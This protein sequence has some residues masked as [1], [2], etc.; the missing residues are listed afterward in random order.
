MNPEQGKDFLRFS[1]G[2]SRAPVGGLDNLKLI[3]QKKDIDK[4]SV[5]HACF[6][7]FSLPDYKN[8]EIT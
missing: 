2:S 7:I 1:T 5:A 4:L 6:N 8:R 3:I